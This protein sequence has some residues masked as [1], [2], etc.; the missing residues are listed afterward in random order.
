[1]SLLAYEKVTTLGGGGRGEQ[2][3]SMH[4]FLCRNKGVSVFGLPRVIFTKLTP[5]LVLNLGA[6][7]KSELDVRN[8]IGFLTEVIRWLLSG[9]C[10]VYNGKKIFK[11][12]FQQQK[13]GH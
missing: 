3:T 7:S 5:I 13:Q 9:Q 1:M 2:W 10:L 11:I 4:A 12:T 8:W 6:K